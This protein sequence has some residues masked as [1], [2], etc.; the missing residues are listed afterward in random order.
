MYDKERQA[1]ILEVK[2]YGLS[3]SRPSRVA[4]LA[5]GRTLAEGEVG[6]L[7]PYGVQE[8]RMKTSFAPTAKELSTL[9]VVFYTDGQEVRRDILRY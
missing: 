8:L 4:V 7:L 6:K 5:D 2:N 3:A 9:T 1:L